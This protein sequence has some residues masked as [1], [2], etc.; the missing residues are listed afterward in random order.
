MNASPGRDGAAT[1][2]LRAFTLV[3]LLTVIATIAILAAIL[4]PTLAGARTAASRARTRV[5]FGQWIMAIEAF[6]QE[7]GRYPEFDGS[8]K[9]NG[10]ASPTPSL[11]HRFHD[12][13]AGH[14]RDGSA[15]AAEV[16]G[17]A[18]AGS[19]NF[20]RM[21]FLVFGESDFFPP[22]DPLSERRNL[23]R[24]GFESAEIAVLVDR[25]LDGIIDREDY[26]EL[27]AVEVPEGNGR[28]LRP[29]MDDFGDGIRAGV[30]FYSAP[31]RALD[32]SQLICSWK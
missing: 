28:V 30:I 8:G 9:V 4:I 7:Y 18:A 6:R 22:D 10:G 25:N 14:R 1:R 29:R 24:D 26:A 23:L 3:E 31:P 17:S 12:I 2:R 15:L 13:L 16:G 11:E 5:Q 32:F 19:Q 20:R 21:R 27:P